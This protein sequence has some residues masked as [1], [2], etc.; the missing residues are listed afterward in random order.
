MKGR[1]NPIKSANPASSSFARGL[2]V[3][4][5]ERLDLG[6]RQRSR[7]WRLHQF[8]SARRGL[9]EGFDLRR[10]DRRRRNRCTTVRLQA[11]VG[12]ATDMPQLGKNHPAFGVHCL[13]DMAPA[14]N[15]CGVI[16]PGV[17]A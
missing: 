9:D 10:L 3:L 5:D 2:G 13:R 1:P 4:P 17:Q 15:L 6:S 16:I 14:V 11:R 7:H 12:H 8:T